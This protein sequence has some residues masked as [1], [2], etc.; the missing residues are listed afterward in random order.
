MVS[1]LFATYYPRVVAVSEHIA[2]W[3]A[4]AGITAAV[5]IGGYLW[6]TADLRSTRSRTSLFKLSG[7]GIKK[8]DVERFINGY[9]KSYSKCGG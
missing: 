7:G 2:P 6:L 9:E 8:D 3:H 5:V 4:A 1:E